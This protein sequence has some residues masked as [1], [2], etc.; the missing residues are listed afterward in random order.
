MFGIEDPAIWGAYLLSLLAAALCVVYGL[1]NWNRGDDEVVEPE[2][3]A[4]EEEEREV[5]EA[6]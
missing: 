3:V 1:W 5:D 6:L 2:D 4:W